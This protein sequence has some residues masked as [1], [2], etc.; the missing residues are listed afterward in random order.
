[1]TQTM[2]RIDATVDYLLDHI[3]GDIIVGAP[4]GIGKPNPL[5]NALYRRIKANPSRRLKIITALSLEKP[6]GRSDIERHFLEPFVERVFGDYPDLDYVKDLRAGSLPPHIEIL[7]FFLKTGDYLGNSTAQQGY[8]STNYTFV[9][10][11]MAL[12]G[13][14]VIMQAVA[15]KEEGGQ[16]KLS[17]SSNTDVTYEA[18]ERLQAIP[19]HHFL[20]VG[21][22]NHALPFMPNQAEIP[23]AFFDLLVT[24]PAGTHHLFSPPNMKV[25]TPDYAIGLHA[26]SLVRDG[27][28]LQIGIG[29]LGDAIAQ[30]LILRDRHPDSFA[31][32]LSELCHKQTAG[33][34]LERFEEG[35]YGCS[36][37]FV[38]GFL[39]LIEAGIVR[40][41]VF[42]D[43]TL[44]QL[45]NSGAITPV[46]DAQTLRALRDAGRISSPLSQGDVD[47]LT[48]FGILLPGV[49][50]RD[51]TLRHETHCVPATLDDASLALIATHLLGKRL[52]AGIHMHGGFFLGP[53]DF[54]QRLRSMPPAELAHIEMHRIDFINQ[55]GSHAALASAQRRRASFINTTMMVTLLG[56]AVSDGLENGQVVSG[57]GGQYNFVAMGHALPDARSILMLRATRESGGEISSNIV[58]NYGHTTIPRHLRDIVV[59][60]YGVAE[61]RG[62]SDAEVVKRLIQIADSRFQHQLVEIAKDKGKLEADWEV[63]EAWRHNLPEALEARLLPWQE[64]GLLPDFPFG[65]DFTSDELAM[66]RVLQK[67]KR[68]SGHP[69]ELVLAAMR[70]LFDDKPVPPQWLARLGLDEAGGLKQA[71]MRRLFVG[72]L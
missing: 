12:H 19:G 55:L 66:I 15:A 9:A 28:T 57:V 35:L 10:R 7:E 49:V 13:V 46:P 33:R 45:L 72:N 8:I 68:A 17:L 62:Q 69:V 59:T 36:E 26:A 61:L 50:L 51:G 20:T 64:A 3:A 21:V 42:A 1:M 52:K 2:D 16:L 30:A 47:F 65:T 6:A 11:D 60:E 67:L 5:L 27:G 38:N 70:G 39:K 4:L 23:P 54:Y 63:P 41:E 37:M 29:A 14:N 32:L 56:A 22:I 44:Q 48:H 53:E 18:V 25:D 24:D 71:L 43:A 31:N 58:W 40:R 34:S